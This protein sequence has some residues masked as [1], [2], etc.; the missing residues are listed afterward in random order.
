M[1]ILDLCTTNL[2]N[3]DQEMEKQ[4][5]QTFSYKKISVKPDE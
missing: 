4:R 1:E 3:V 5:L 2:I